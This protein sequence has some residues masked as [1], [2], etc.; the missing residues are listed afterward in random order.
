MDSPG[1]AVLVVDDRELTQLGLRVILDQDPRVSVVGEAWSHSEAIM[2]QRSRHPDVVLID[3]LAQTID[4]QYLARRLTRVDGVEPARIL[5]LVN[6]MD[7]HAWGILR[8]GARG[9]LLKRSGPAELVAAL[10]LVAAGYM[11]FTPSV[12]G[13]C[14]GAFGAQAGGGDRGSSRAPRADDST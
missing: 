14:P 8:S 6:E 13:S 4:P 11:V 9:V 12:A 5:V 3:A 7:E 2:F 1:L 10:A